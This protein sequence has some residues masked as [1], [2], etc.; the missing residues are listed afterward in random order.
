M[1]IQEEKESI[2]YGILHRVMFLH[3]CANTS[4]SKPTKRKQESNE[5]GRCDNIMKFVQ[6]PS[7]GHI[8]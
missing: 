8:K 6:R 7:K 4:R 2:A 3:D 5:K 1:K